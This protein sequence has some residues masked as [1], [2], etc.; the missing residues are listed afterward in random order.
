M[1]S[2]TETPGSTEVG[3]RPT[4]A[5][6]WSRVGAIAGYVAGG[7][8]FVTTGLFL[9]DVTGV[10]GDSNV[11]PRAGGGVEHSIAAYYA[12]FFHYQHHI[13]WDIAIRDSVGPIGFLAV[14][15]MGVVVR[16][17]VGAQHPLGQLTALFFQ[18]GAL[19]LALDG[20]LYLS[21]TDFWRDSGWAAEP[22]SNMIAAGRALEAVN[23]VTNF[24]SLGGYVTLALGLVCLGQLCRTG[25][26]LP[27]RLAPFAFAEALA[28]IGVV[29][30]SLL[31]PESVYD[32]L[33][34]LVGVLLG[35]LVLVW[36]GR[37]FAKD[38]SAA[39]PAR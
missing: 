7:A 25:P 6:A 34:L 4:Y 27:S 38:G 33:A 29:V 8:L 10:L 2:I 39:Q 21:G 16:H 32:V 17:T 28:L 26:R 24:L 9:L 18:V 12:S 15:V 37:H 31:G 11:V 35:P 22:A 23:S 5:R 13:L 36:L 3:P 14:M 1:N 19:L 20:L 30:T